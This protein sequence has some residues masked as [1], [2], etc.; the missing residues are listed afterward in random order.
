MGQRKSFQTPT[1]AKMDTTPRIGREIGSTIDRRV[2][3]GEAPSMEA[4]SRSSWGTESKN[5]FSRKML[6]ALVTE[7]SQIAHGEFSRLRSKIGTSSTV[8]YCGTTSTVAGIIS[9]ASIRPRIALPRTGRS[10]DSE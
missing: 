7:G 5:R 8:R 1:I 4:A 2:R 9:V 10:L 6:K 3:I